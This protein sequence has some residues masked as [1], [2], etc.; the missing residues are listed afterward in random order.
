MQKSEL[1]AKYAKTNED[2]ILLAH[3]LDREA[4]CIHKNIPAEG[5]F[6]DPRQQGLI[7]SLAPHL[8]IQPVLWGGYADAERRMI[9][10]LPDYMDAPPE[11]A[12]TIIRATHRDSRPP[13]HRDYLGS[14]LGLGVD[15]AG[16]GDI[17]TD[18]NGAQIIVRA[19]LAD[20][21]ATHYTSAG[22]VSLSVTALP[23]TDLALPAT[24][25]VFK[26]ASLA[27]LR[28]DA[29]LAAAFSVS[30]TLAADAVRAQRVFVN[31]LPLTKGDKLL[32]VGDKVRWQGKGRFILEETGG[33]SRKGRLFVTFRF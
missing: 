1:I 8:T 20:F 10:F 30:R 31:N 21:F 11:D 17:L 2:K 27:S 28:A 13:G 32:S 24:E 4:V 14:A 29:V 16:V 7:L 23:L 12:L 33:T 18:E 26:T 5:P 25:P 3:I 6:L 19:S 15:R 9:F 22:R